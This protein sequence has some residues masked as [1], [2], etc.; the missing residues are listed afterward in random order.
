MQL[1]QLNQLPAQQA[2][3]AFLDCCASHRWAAAMTQARPFA[4]LQSLARQAEFHWRLLDDADRLEAF[5]GHAR[6]GDMQ[7]LQRKYESHTQVEQGQV[8]DAPLQT[9]QQ[10]HDLNQTYEQKFGFMFIVCAS[11][12]SALQ[13]LQLLQARLGN[14]RVQ[15]MA[16]AAAE[17]LKIT[18][19]RLTRMLEPDQ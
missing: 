15:E 5:S 6:I 7:A 1:L 16:N 8:G 4:D 10:L 12:K 2:L 11:G 17:Q 9:L 3:T 13:M 19:L 14:S 18:Q